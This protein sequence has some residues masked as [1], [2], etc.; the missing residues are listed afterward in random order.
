MAEADKNTRRADEAERAR[1][2]GA[3]EA[4]AFAT[5]AGAM[6]LGILTGV[7]AAQHRSEHPQPQS[8][9][10]TLPPSPAEIAPAQ[11]AA[12]DHRPIQQDGH[13]TVAQAAA[14][15]SATTIHADTAPDP[16]FAAEAASH[17]GAVPAHALVSSIAVWEFSAPA[18]RAHAG[19]I[20]TGASGATAPSSADPG[21]LDSGTFIHQISDTITRLIDAPLAIVSDTIAGLSATIGQLTSSLSDTI[22]HLT[23]SLTGAVTGLVHDAPVAGVLEPVLT[24]ILGPAPTPTDFSGTAGHGASLLDTAGAVPIAP[25]QPFPLHLGFL[26]QPTIDGHETHD[27][28][29][30]ALGVHHF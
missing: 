29:F 14:V 28:A 4:A 3:S 9:E 8:A 22:S 12:A 30:S 20:S 6:L 27:G 1:H 10:P 5:T 16:G 21:L 15:D 25:L 24:D 18:D 26:G 2:I 7:E 19:T 23:D 13:G 17:G 11:P